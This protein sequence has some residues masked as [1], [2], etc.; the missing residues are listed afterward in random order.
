MHSGIGS[1]HSPF[2]AEDSVDDYDAKACSPPL[3]HT[4]RVRVEADTSAR[5]KLYYRDLAIRKD[6]DNV[7]FLQVRPGLSVHMSAV[8]WHS[9][10]GRMVGF[11]RSAT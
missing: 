10:I 2:D 11:V 5:C 4:G 7:P 9:E 8:E 3:T 6:L 1:Y